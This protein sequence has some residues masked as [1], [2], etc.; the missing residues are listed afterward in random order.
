MASREELRNLKND[1]L[2]DPCWDI[3]D[4]EGFEEH[5]RELAEFQAETEA[6]WQKKRDDRIAAKAKELE[7]SPALAWH[8]E[9][10]EDRIER[11]EEKVD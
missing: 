10:L 11:L 8:I 9:F 4:T 1:W 6:R 5:A 7:C 3:A 2:S